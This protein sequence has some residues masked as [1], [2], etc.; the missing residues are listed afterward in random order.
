MLLKEIGGVFG[1]GR[2]LDIFDLLAVDPSSKVEFHRIIKEISLILHE[3]F[4][5][6]FLNIRRVVI[7][8][9]PFFVDSFEHPIGVVKFARLELN[10][11]LRITP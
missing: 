8:T 1:P 6:K 9:F 7:A 10:H 5:Y 3:E 11:P 2:Q 4:G